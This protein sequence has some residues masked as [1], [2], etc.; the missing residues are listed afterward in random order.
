ML[1]RLQIM[2]RSVG[3]TVCP[4]AMHRMAWSSIHSRTRSEARASSRSRPAT[5]P[6][7][8]FDR[9]G[10]AYRLM[11]LSH[12]A[13]V[14]ARFSS[15]MRA[16]MRPGTHIMRFATTQLPGRR[17]ATRRT[18]ATRIAGRHVRRFRRDVVVGGIGPQLVGQPRG[19][20]SR[21]APGQGAGARMAETACPRHGGGARAHPLAQD[22]RDKPTPR[23]PPTRAP[24][25][26]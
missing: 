25:C 22:L 11:I 1:H 15:D 7:G 21:M 13:G 2:V 18:R 16:R 20:P 26:G 3:V 24:P 9:V 14:H 19:R 10:S 8:E 6:A 23:A 12:W 5:R 17:K 4:F